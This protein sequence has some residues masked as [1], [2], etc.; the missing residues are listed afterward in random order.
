M[1][2]QQ[3]IELTGRWRTSPLLHLVVVVVGAIVASDG[4]V[5]KAETLLSLCSRW[6]L[7]MELELLWLT[8]VSVDE[9]ISAPYL[10]GG[11]TAGVSVQGGFL[12]SSFLTG[13]LKG[14]WIGT[15]MTSGFLMAGFK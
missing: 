14:V 3:C 7:L 12:S 2:L 9:L 10:H 11:W 1:H 15:V 8:D 5:L 13:L 4:Q 6:L